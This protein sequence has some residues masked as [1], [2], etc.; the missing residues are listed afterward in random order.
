MRDFGQNRKLL[1]SGMK[2]SCGEKQTALTVLHVNAVSLS[3]EIFYVTIP[4]QG[5]EA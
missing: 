2:I 4:K 1:P 5:T 3:N